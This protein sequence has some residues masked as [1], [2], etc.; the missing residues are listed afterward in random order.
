LKPSRARGE[1]RVEARRASED[2]GFTSTWR[3]EKWGT[4]V[5]QVWNRSI[6]SSPRIQ[7]VPLSKVENLV[8]LPF[9]TKKSHFHIVYRAR[10]FPSFFLSHRNTTSCRLDWTQ[11]QTSVE[12]HVLIMMENISNRDRFGLNNS[13][14][15]QCVTKMLRGSFNV[16]QLGWIRR[17]SRLTNRITPSLASLQIQMKAV[18]DVR[19]TRIGNRKISW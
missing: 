6:P 5:A 14:W 15:N 12:R 13:V 9:W 3:V 1:S 10:T 16:R 18:D 17:A 8:K 19:S 11:L 2:S 7:K 4:P